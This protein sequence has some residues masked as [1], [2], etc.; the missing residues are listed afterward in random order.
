MLCFKACCIVQFKQNVLVSKFCTN[1]S[2]VSIVLRVCFLWDIMFLV[3]FLCP[4][5]RF[6]FYYVSYILNLFCFSYCIVSKQKF[7]IDMY[8]FEMCAPKRTMKPTHPKHAPLRTHAQ[9]GLNYF[10]TYRI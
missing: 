1:N 7:Q 2:R 3:L 10:V 5:F 6:Y 9:I 8:L 4:S